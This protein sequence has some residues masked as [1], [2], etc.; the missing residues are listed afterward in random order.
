ML[1]WPVRITMLE[2]MLERGNSATS[3]AVASARAC[4]TIGAAAGATRSTRAGWAKPARS[5]ASAYGAVSRA[6]VQAVRARAA[7]KSSVAMG[8]IGVS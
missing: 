3:A 6:S 7:A 8:R 4:A 1:A 5:R 2:T